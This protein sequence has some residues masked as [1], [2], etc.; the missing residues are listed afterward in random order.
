MV[1]KKARKKRMTDEELYN[2]AETNPKYVKQATK[3]LDSSTRKIARKAT[4]LKKLWFK[5]LGY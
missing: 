1:I 5:G 4:G 2:L 3:R